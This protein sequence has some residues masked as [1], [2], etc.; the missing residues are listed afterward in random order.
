MSDLYNS[1]KL[2]G[3]S[4]VDGVFMSVLASTISG[5]GMDDITREQTSVVL[6]LRSEVARETFEVKRALLDLEVNQMDR[7]DRSPDAIAKRNSIAT[8]GRVLDLA[9]RSND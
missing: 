8:F 1:E 4:A 2:P 7:K 6:K 5:R 9:L 3:K